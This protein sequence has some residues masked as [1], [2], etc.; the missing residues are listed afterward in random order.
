MTYQATGIV[1]KLTTRAAVSKAGKPYTKHGV[2]LDSGQEFELDGFKQIYRV[3]DRVSNVLVREKFRQMTATGV[4]NEGLG[5]P[6]LPVKGAPGIAGTTP[7]SAPTPSPVVRGGSSSSWSPRGVFPIDPEDGQMSIIRQ[8]ALTNAVAVV[9]PLVR[10]V[11]SENISIADVAGDREALL[12]EALSSVPDLILK[13][14][15]KF[16]SFSSGQYDKIAAEE[17]AK[18]ATGAIG[19]GAAKEE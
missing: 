4:P 5:L 10:E 8:N 1:T 15:Y 11:L 3:G 18:K 6:P 16:Q 13:V 7:T 12:D 2:E 19:K 17:V 9:V 14:A